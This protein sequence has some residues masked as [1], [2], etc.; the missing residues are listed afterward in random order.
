MLKG[1]GAPGDDQE[2]VP[3]WSKEVFNLFEVVVANEAPLVPGTRGIEV[4]Y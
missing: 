4:E 3:G 2:D 1:D